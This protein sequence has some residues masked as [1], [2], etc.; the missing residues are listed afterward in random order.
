MCP[1]QLHAGVG[2]DGRAVTVVLNPPVVPIGHHPSR[3][4]SL[5][6]R[7]KSMETSI[8]HRHE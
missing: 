7:S 8:G 3:A 6:G 1:N 5:S 4:V 2:Q